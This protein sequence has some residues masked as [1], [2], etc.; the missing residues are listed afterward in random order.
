[1]LKIEVTD[2]VIVKHITAKKGPNAGQSFDIPEQVCFA[3]VPGEK[4]PV[5]V[6]RG[7]PRDGQPLQ[8]GTYLLDPSSIFVDRF[9]QMGI[10]SQF[11]VRPLSPGVQKAA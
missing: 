1:M 5:K 8:Q 6:I 9:G 10:R 3:H 4:Y 2:E 7:V 11:A